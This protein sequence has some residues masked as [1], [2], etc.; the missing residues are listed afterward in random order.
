MSRERSMCRRH[1]RSRSQSR[2]SSSSISSSSSRCSC[3]SSC[4]CRSTNSGSTR[5]RSRSSSSSR[6][7]SSSSISCHSRRSSS[8]RSSSSSRS[9]GNGGSHSSRSRSSCTCIS[10]S[11]GRSRHRTLVCRPSI[12]GTPRGYCF[13]SHASGGGSRGESMRAFVVPL[14]GSLRVVDGRDIHG[15]Q[16]EGHFLREELRELL[17][18]QRPPPTRSRDSLPVV[19][20]K[21]S[22]R[23]HISLHILVPTQ[24]GAA[25]VPSRP[26]RFRLTCLVPCWSSCGL[27]RLSTLLIHP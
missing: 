10:C 20:R 1:C 25:R 15:G 2:S 7:S 17:E 27:Q 26:C 8:R 18:E 5:S 24:L 13:A 12:A 19:R 9:R 3:S 11:H 16:M 4:S 14:L 21:P 22:A 23:T 6:N